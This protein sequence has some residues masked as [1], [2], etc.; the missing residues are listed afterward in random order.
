MAST[1]VHE[2]VD[3]LAEEHD[4]EHHDNFIT[5]YIFSQDHK[6]IAKQY[7]I[8]GIFW[9]ILGGG[10]S[11]MEVSHRGSLFK[12]VAQRAELPEHFGELAEIGGGKDRD[13]RF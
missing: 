13:A 9:A 6:T 10:M 8:T 7:L 3:H 2:H 4:H 11:V 1:A 12:D 5:K